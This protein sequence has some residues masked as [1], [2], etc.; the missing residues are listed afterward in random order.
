MTVATPTI[1][2]AGKPMPA[3]YALASFDIRLEVNRVPSAEL[4]ILD[5]DAAKQ[6]FA[7]SDTDF[8]APGAEV[9]I[10]MRYEGSPDES[11][12][13]GLVTRHGVEAA[14]RGSALIIGL[15]DAAVKLAGTRKNA[16]FAQMSDNQIMQQL[17]GDAGVAPGELAAT[18]PIHATMVQY[19]ATPWDFLVMRAEALGML[20]TSELGIVSV[21]PM[22]AP[23][24]GKP[25]HSLNWGIDVIY[26]LD[27]EADALHP[28]KAVESAAWDPMQVAMTNPAVQ[29][30]AKAPLPGNLVPDKLA[31]AVGRD[32]CKLVHPVP[33]VEGELQAWADARLS[34]SHLSMLRGRL[35]LQGKNGLKLLDTLEIKGIGTRFNGATQITG[36]RHRYDLQG[37][38]TDL[39]FGLSPDRH[40]QREDIADVPANGLLPPLRGLQVGVVAAFEEDP[41]KELRVKVVLPSV[42]A[43]VTSAV[44]ARLSSPDAELNRGFFFRPEMGDEVVVG[45]LNDDPRH[46]IILG[47]LFGSKNKPP[48]TLKPPSALN[49]SKGI[50]TKKGTSISF[51]DAEKPSVVIETIGKNKIVID[52]A[53]G[54]ISLMDQNGNKIVLDANGITLDAGGNAVT[55][56]GAKVDVA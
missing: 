12:F 2:S 47:A 46:P 32:S 53:T 23:G 52:D 41:Q 8:F 56:K 48:M 38:R 24:G 18:K 4:R 51:V 30:T 9:E 37:W 43:K 3:T 33:V 13:K 7:V 10:K 1:T 26:D 6:L 25:K 39:Q 15:K 21:R 29:A 5:G 16:V 20:V 40:C 35:S 45:F 49:E 19:D 50:V 28:Y 22:I 17:L 14:A 34:R 42:D 55:I 31:A 54:G 27:I 44:W 36:I 11:I